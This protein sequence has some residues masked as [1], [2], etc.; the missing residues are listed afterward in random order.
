[1]RLLNTNKLIV[2][3]L[4]VSQNDEWCCCKFR[5]IFQS[6]TFSIDFDISLSFCCCF[7]SMTVNENILDILFYSKELMHVIMLSPT[8]TKKTDKDHLLKAYGFSVVR[9]GRTLIANQCCVEWIIFC[10]PMMTYCNSFPNSVRRLTAL[11]TISF[12]FFTSVK[13]WCYIR[14]SD[15]RK[16][17]WSP[18]NKHGFAKVPNIAIKADKN[19]LWISILGNPA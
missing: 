19:L 18:S 17:Q 5:R 14:S 7:S 12:V 4:I 11:W 6:L 1:M 10:L 9:V 16:N 2:H 15:G 8:P 13:K 3:I